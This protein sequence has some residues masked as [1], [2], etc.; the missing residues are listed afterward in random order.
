MQTPEGKTH[1]YTSPE[2]Y[3]GTHLSYEHQQNGQQ[4][5]EEAPFSQIF[6]QA[7]NLTPG[8][9]IIIQPRDRKPEDKLPSE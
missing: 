8:E 4:E 2:S 7:N 5:S 1:G 9:S 3:R 6:L